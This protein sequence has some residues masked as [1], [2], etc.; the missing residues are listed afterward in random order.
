[1]T[2]D[3]IS[4]PIIGYNIIEHLVSNYKEKLN[5]PKS[6]VE[7]IASLSSEERAET[8]VNLIQKGEE[9]SESE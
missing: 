1:M 8:M 9:E 6:L 5:L 4:A 7:M 2:E 3:E